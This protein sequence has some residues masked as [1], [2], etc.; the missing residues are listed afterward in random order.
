MKNILVIHPSVERQ[1][2]LE[3]SL[4]AD[5]IIISN[6]YNLI[7][8]F[9]KTIQHIGFIYH[10]NIASH[11]PFFNNNQLGERT[12]FFSKEFH[13]FIS[14]ILQITTK[15]V[16]ID[17]ITCNIDDNNIIQEIHDIMK[18]YKF[19][20][21]IRYSLDQTGN[22]FLGG[23]WIMESHDINI[24]NIYFT[25]KIKEWRVILQLA[26]HFAYID[27][28]HNIH[29]FGNNNFNQLG[30]QR[31]YT[32]DSGRNIEI[33]QNIIYNHELSSQ[34]HD[35]KPLYV[36]CGQNHTAILFS[37]GS[38]G[39]LG[40]NFYGQ[41]GVPD[42]FSDSS[43]S[44]YIN[45][46]DICL[47]SVDVYGA[48][49]DI[50][51]AKIESIAVSDFDTAF[52]VSNLKNF[53]TDFS[54]NVFITG[55]R[56][57]KNKLYAT[58]VKAGNPVCRVRN[59]AMSENRIV[60]L[61]SSGFLWHYTPNTSSLDQNTG[62]FEYEFQRPHTDMSFIQIDV[63]RNHMA[64]ISNSNDGNRLYVGLDIGSITHSN[65]TGNNIIG[66]QFHDKFTMDLSLVIERQISKIEQLSCGREH[67][68]LM[69]HSNDKLYPAA[70]GKNTFKEFGDKYSGST[71]WIHNK[72]KNIANSY[73]T[74]PNVYKFKTMI[75]IACGPFSTFFHFLDT[76][77]NHRYQILGNVE[78]DLSS[79]KV[80]NIIP[81]SY[82]VH[83]EN[84]SYMPMFSIMNSSF[85]NY[86][87]YFDVTSPILYITQDHKLLHFDVPSH[88][89]IER[90]NSTENR[91]VVVDQSTN[92]F[93]IYGDTYWKYIDEHFN[94]S[95]INLIPDISNASF[96]MNKQLWT[97]TGNDITQKQFDLLQNIEDLV[98]PNI[99]N[100]IDLNLLHNT[101]RSFKLGI[102]TESVNDPFTYL[103]INFNRDVVYIIDASNNINNNFSLDISTSGVYDVSD[104]LTVELNTQKFM[105]NTNY[106]M[107]YIVNDER[108][109]KAT[110]S[111]ET[112]NI[113]LNDAYIISSVFVSEYFHEV[114]RNMYIKLKD[115][116]GDYL[117]IDISKARDITNKANNLLSTFVPVMRVCDEINMYKLIP[118]F[119]TKMKE[120]REILI[121]FDNYTFGI[122]MDYNVY[123]TMENVLT[124]LNKSIIDINNRIN[125]FN[126]NQIIP[127]DIANAIS[128]P[129]I[130]KIQQN[131]ITLIKLGESF[132][133]KTFPQ[134][135][136][137]INDKTKR[138]NFFWRK[139]IH[140]S[141]KNTDFSACTVNSFYNDKKT[142]EQLFEKIPEYATDYNILD[143]Y[144]TI[145]KFNF[146]GTSPPQL[147]G[148]PS[149]GSGNIISLNYYNRDGSSNVSFI[150]NFGYFYYAETDSDDNL[151]INKVN[152]STSKNLSFQSHSTGKNH[153]ALLYNPDTNSDNI[154]LTA[155]II[156]IFENTTIY[157]QTTD[158]CGNIYRNVEAVSCGSHHTS[159][160]DINGNVII[161]GLGRTWNER[162]LELET[163]RMCNKRIRSIETTNAELFLR[164]YFITDIASWGDQDYGGFTNYNFKQID[165][166]YDSKK[167]TSILKVVTNGFA[168][169][170]IENQYD[171][172]GENRVKSWGK[173]IPLHI[174]IYNVQDV[175][176]TKSFID[177]SNI[178][179]TDDTTLF[180]Q[181]TG[182]Y[183]AFAACENEKSNKNSIY[184]WGQGI[185]YLNSI[186]VLQ[187]E[188]QDINENNENKK[189]NHRII[190][191]ASTY[192]SFSFLL[193]NHIVHH[194]DIKLQN[195][196]NSLPVT[197]NGNSIEISRLYSND[198]FF[199]GIN[200]YDYTLY[201]WDSS[202]ATQ[203]NIMNTQ[204]QV[205][206]FYPFGRSFLLRYNDNMF[207]L[208]S[209]DLSTNT[210]HLNFYD[211]S[212][213]TTHFQM[214][215]V[216][217]FFNTAMI[218]DH[219]N[220]ASNILIF[221]NYNT[222]SGIVPSALY[223]ASTNDISLDKIEFVNALL[224]EDEIYD[225]IITETTDTCNNIFRLDTSL[226]TSKLSSTDVTLIFLFYISG[227]TLHSVK[228]ALLP[229]YHINS[230]VGHENIQY[231]TYFIKSNRISNLVLDI[232]SNN[233]RL[234]ASRP[235]RHK[236]N[237]AILYTNEK[238]I[239][240]L[241]NDGKVCI[242]G[243]LDYGGIRIYMSGNNER[244]EV[245]NSVQ[246]I[247][248]LSNVV[249]VYPSQRAFTL[250]TRVFST[251]SDDKYRL[252]PMRLSK[253]SL[254]KIQL[255]N[256]SSGVDI[257]LG[258]FLQEMID[259]NKPIPDIYETRNTIIRYIMLMNP[260]VEYFSIPLSDMHIDVLFDSLPR[261]ISN[262]FTNGD[263]TNITLIRPNSF[264]SYTEYFEFH[265]NDILF[266]F[267]FQVGHFFQLHYPNNRDIH[268]R[269]DFEDTQPVYRVYE[270]G[271]NIT[272]YEYENQFGGISN[273]NYIPIS[274]S[275]NS[276]R[277][278]N[279]E[280]I[281]ISTILQGGLLLI[282][283]FD[284]VNPNSRLTSWGDPH[285]G[286]LVTPNLIY[287]NT[288]DSQNIL[289]ANGLQDNIRYVFDYEDMFLALVNDISCHVIV[290][291]DEHTNSIYDTSYQDISNVSWVYLNENEKIIALQ[292]LNGSIIEIQNPK[293]LQKFNDIYNHFVLLD[294]IAIGIDSNNS[295]TYELFLTDTNRINNINNDINNITNVKFITSIENDI[296]IYYGKKVNIVKVISKT[297]TNIISEMSVNYKYIYNKKVS[298]IQRLDQQLNKNTIFKITSNDLLSNANIDICNNFTNARVI[299]DSSGYI[300]SLNINYN[301]IPNHIDNRHMN[302]IYSNKSSFTSIYNRYNFSNQI[303]SLIPI[304]I[305]VDNS[306]DVHGTLSNIQLYNYTLQIDTS[307]SPNTFYLT[308]SDGNTKDDY[309]YIDTT[310]IILDQEFRSLRYGIVRDIFRL[311]PYIMSF[312]ISYEN[313]ALNP[314][315]GSNYV[316]VVQN[317]YHIDT[318][319]NSI[320]MDASGFLR[321]LH[322]IVLDK[323]NDHIKIGTSNNFIRIVRN[324]DNTYSILNSKFESIHN[325]SNI[326]PDKNNI[327]NFDINGT[328][329][330]NLTKLN[331]FDTNRLGYNNTFILIG[332]GIFIGNQ[333]L[334][335]LVD[336]YVQL[337]AY[338]NFS[339]GGLMLHTLYPLVQE[340]MHSI[341]GNERA[342][343]AL[344]EN[345]SNNQRVIAWG[346]PFFGAYFKNIYTI[347]DNTG[348]RVYDIS[349]IDI[350]N[351]TK[352]IGI[353]DTIQL[354]NVDTSNIIQIYHTNFAFAGLQANGSVIAWGMKNP[355]YGADIKSIES[356]NIGII[357]I[358]G[359]K[360]SFLAI[361]EKNIMNKIFHTCIHWGHNIHNINILNDKLKNNNELIKCVYHTDRAFLIHT[362]KDNLYACGDI[363]F[364]GVIPL[365]IQDDL[366]KSKRI[367]KVV[368]NHNSF[369][370]IF[371]DHTSNR[372]NILRIWGDVS[373]SDIEYNFIDIIDI[374]VNNTSYVALKSNGSLMSWTAYNNTNL[375]YG[376]IIPYRIMFD[377]TSNVDKIVSN[378]NAFAAIK[379]DDVL[380][381]WG[382]FMDSDQALSEL[383]VESPNEIIRYKVDTYR[384]N[385]ENSDGIIKTIS[386]ETIHTFNTQRNIDIS[387]MNFVSIYST[388][389]AFSAID[390]NSNIIFWGDLTQPFLIY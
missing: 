281:A 234:A 201:A 157:P 27:D 250:E 358:Y 227:N 331:S 390:E 297:R 319:I 387:N 178:P 199:L 289:L 320:H 25:D 323:P 136:E 351:T 291:K 170:S 168:F 356:D 96:E 305:N 21:Q 1:D 163:R 365:Y 93:K 194:F 311:N 343:C 381:S 108:I 377:L 210:F 37:D 253:T 184:I 80:R 182:T 277:T 86:N 388:D 89:F 225:Y 341:I 338:G 102:I 322:Y 334:Q 162:F 276:F 266:V 364:G 257:H 110:P 361:K 10:N 203:F 299:M 312:D 204:R 148:L 316:R 6:E 107:A 208:L 24:K 104:I 43:S 307:F 263:Q 67:I 235:F 45:I 384:L 52:V 267:M 140:D 248:D 81:T 355:N 279:S 380:F 222:P 243:D 74:S 48:D 211:F 123:N 176:G 56:Q 333:R 5:T 16:I 8:S 58:K 159:I 325:A 376:G 220:D 94:D 126:K 146:N 236:T 116:W 166:E 271:Q 71:T 219:T 315:I 4:N 214:D 150:D 295:I 229:V 345:M 105:R 40:S 44:N 366:D 378:A 244:Y 221:E 181:Y 179:K 3:K 278:I 298:S 7:H 119:N 180:N 324:Y 373:L 91:I 247:E 117:Y 237:I 339:Y 259:N 70:I 328:I 187:F 121:N 61:D 20:I 249:A 50:S 367:H 164:E 54:S 327:Y 143:K 264:L 386:G 9:R 115:Y 23:D 300:P 189:D 97:D 137:E 294:W 207:D 337:L 283:P 309:R 308:D 174:D 152:I 350:N 363:S 29:L 26:E 321:G 60:A 310:N 88:T 41:L 36:H 198:H 254:N 173:H 76:S 34:S 191:M 242:D 64:A 348:E 360:Y 171:N 114:L 72:D 371:E 124:T 304:K 154:N 216:F 145:I 78:S 270:N 292:D 290:W 332:H 13:N 128:I 286:G 87:E 149:E 19:K 135:L 269:I 280:R 84:Y 251:G 375:Q 230:N 68:A 28:E 147:A 318:T 30:T 42:V 158:V 118:D 302:M 11:F 98:V 92:K 258:D 196:F 131:V 262:I 66:N 130:F 63:G 138:F 133:K 62:M 296:Y 144:I 132:D 301:T 383:Q 209:M 265:E 252:I 193:D 151:T 2:I 47:G 246:L 374:A 241:L 85:M 53:G 175:I 33:N 352:T 82:D 100:S 127:L 349:F 385:T 79:G 177:I 346:S 233:Y 183:S 238:A 347:T 103:S 134:F 255:K 161:T 232:N 129:R 155:R 15:P 273:E 357:E 59:I 223:K 51:Y 206:Q 342:F 293:K 35:R 156:D 336:E 329:S 65:S 215:K 239:C 379:T 172:E 142:F 275:V 362:I 83:E 17:L 261:D 285:G 73:L 153:F 330:N 188:I 272:M 274:T 160:L 167:K 195:Q 200:A 306:M 31:F 169:A 125:L 165:N 226:N 245:P 99:D 109:N 213:N 368:S 284:D 95:S 77:N 353:D 190:H 205:V 313:F 282:D 49:T 370:V 112:N 256:I 55:K 202:S 212:S 372:N 69:Y 90:T 120:I 101:G 389:Y 382:Q 224:N 303:Y 197:Y 186:D 14:I 185:Q 113:D 111:T 22:S 18:Q 106:M 287:R 326:N 260:E 75:D 359:N 240:Q 314:V 317:G 32:D 231:N 217:T 340:N 39:M 228:N 57:L 268:F 335:I 139:I 46:T 288:H 12:T 369:S 192:S 218:I 141:L 38:V 354:D 344:Q 122:N